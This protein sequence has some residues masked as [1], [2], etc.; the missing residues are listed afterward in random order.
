M[1]GILATRR[2]RRGFGVAP[3]LYMLGLVGVG[4]GILFSSYSQSI[5]ANI[6]LTNSLAVKNDLTGA[7][8]TLASSAVLDS[9]QTYLCPPQGGIDSSTTTNCTGATNLSTGMIELANVT[10]G[11]VRLPGNAASAAAA[12]SPVEVG[13]F[14]PGSGVKQID[15]WGH[16]YIY[17]RWENKAVNGSDPEITILSAGP[18][19][20]LQSNCG[21]QTACNT[22]SHCDDII[23][24]LNVS[25]TLSHDTLWQAGTIGSTSDVRYG[26]L[27]VDA[28]G[29]V[30][31]PGTLT[32]D[33]SSLLDSL[34]TAAAGITTGSAT[35][36]PTGAISGTSGTFGAV[37]SADNGNFITG[38]GGTVSAANGAFTINTGGAFNAATNQFTVSS[39]GDLA[40][41]SSAF[42]VTAATGNTSIG[43]T[44]GV[45]GMVSLGS[46]MSTIGAVH[47]GTTTASGGNPVYLL[48]VGTPEAG[49]PATYPFYVD[50]S[51]NVTAVNVNAGS[52]TAG[53]VSGGS[54]SA[55]S[56]SDSGTATLSGN[57]TVG[58][59]LAV[60]GNLTGS[61]ATFSG[62]VTAQSFS[63][64]MNI[65]SSGGSGVT[66]TG[67]LPVA[68][69]GTGE[70]DAA[71]ALTNL[72]NTAG[73]VS[74]IIPGADLKSG[75]V[76]STQLDSPASSLTGVYYNNVEVDASGRIIAA[77]NTNY[78]TNS[79]TD[80]AGDAVTVGTS[81]GFT[82][83][84][85]STVMENIT[86]TGA[87]VGTS[88]VAANMLDVYGNASIG[89]SYS[90]IA[91][92]PNGLIVAGSVGIG[93]SN[94]T[95]ALT[96]N[97]TVTAG[98]FV[99][100]GSGLTGINGGSINTG[101]TQGS[102][103]FIGSSGALAQNNGQF[104]WD[105]TNDRLGIGTPAP[106]APLHIVS[107][108][109]TD[110]EVD[111]SNTA[112]ATIV[113]N[114]TSLG[115]H[116]FVVNATGA[117]NWAGEFGISDKTTGMPLLNIDGTNG[118]VGIAGYATVGVV[119]LPPAG[120][121]LVPGRVGIGSNNPI[122][123]LDLSQETDAIALPNGASS[124]R[125]T[126]TQLANGEIR[127]NSGT[128]AVEYWN[129]TTWVSLENSGSGSGI[130]LG[131]SASATNPSR[132]GDVTTGLYSDAAGTVEIASA[133]NMSFSNSAALTLIP[134]G[135]VGI[136]TTSPQAPFDVEVK[137]PSAP[138]WDQGA[139][140]W[141]Q[142]TDPVA[143]SHGL[144]A[145]NTLIMSS[146]NNTY[147]AYGIASEMDEI[148][149]GKSE[150]NTV[151]GLAG[152][153]S[154]K[155][156][157]SAGSISGLGGVEGYVQAN[158]AD[159]VS[160][161]TGVTGLV[162]NIGTGSITNAYA[163]YATNS[164]KSNGSIT[165]GYGVYIENQT[166]ATNNW[167]LYSAGGNNYFGGNVGI[168]TTS[169]SATLHLSGAN[170]NALSGTPLFR[171]SDTT[172][173]SNIAIDNGAAGNA[174]R[175][176]TGNGQTAKNIELQSGSNS[177]Q[178]VLNTNGNVG[179]GS[180]SP[181]VSLD[182]SQKTDA[183]AL[184]NGA[185]SSRPTGTALANGEIRYNSGTSAVEYWNGTTWVSLENSGSGSGIYLGASAS[186]T[187][188]SRNGD[189]TTGLYSDA[190]GTVEIA[191]GGNMS[192]SN[193]AALTLIPTGSVGIGTTSP[194]SL[195]D[196][197]GISIDTANFS[198][199]FTQIIQNIA[200][201]SVG[202]TNFR[203]FQAQM[204]YTS[205][206]NSTANSL[207]AQSGY[208]VD[209]GTGSIGGTLKA[210]SGSVYQIPGAGTVSS[211]V[212][213]YGDVVSTGTASITNAYG[214]QF[215]VNVS[216]GVTTGYGLYVGA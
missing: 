145:Q 123:S 166:G 193:S 152:Y 149:N 62:T 171:L 131:A 194:Q 33:G 15:P 182:L 35:M 136:G 208:I 55:S 144:Y 164:F 143:S 207:I 57:T 121:F 69:G 96:V 23:Y 42:S 27:S 66:F 165:N 204:N 52:V 108:A 36:S 30:I 32:V 127:Y 79:I 37:L 203:T 141:Y 151:Y 78:A 163:L 156:G 86:K 158:S 2:A 39:A 181:L 41:G 48:S 190:A 198:P 4:A 195:V 148:T 213:V 210:L 186:A 110:I 153:A 179:I 76:T 178:L 202:S 64:T 177:Y 155:T 172:Q 97:G 58:G 45:T 212:G 21:A 102:V 88:A 46:S 119:T 106:S 209:S 75:T 25:N 196:V 85:G 199:N 3:I 162:Q 138:T 216:S 191:S 61:N 1:H 56:I 93:T 132:N 115:G 173:S 130:Y 5:K 206:Q 70:S 200:P 43:G 82:V 124:S 63:G 160:S 44:L 84:V 114:N 187:N 47:V 185:S 87:M 90:N 167:A 133:G 112:S 6:S 81:S 154:S 134:T 28:N 72:F 83:T 107:S 59:T 113:L 188:P 49:S 31:V 214:G 40:I 205:A 128:S 53:S 197:E 94:P 174:F 9:T 192:F 105:N 111:S 71:S 12:G 7:A 17:C 137:E 51:G 54:V 16:Y 146:G 150:S 14:A 201:V 101:F 161:A 184:P 68:N 120:S 77:F 168:G 11:D 215:S 67:V 98:A 116:Q 125:P 80:G 60:T 22:T 91:A 29:N 74:G 189:V 38:A 135:S 139:R 170:G 26:N 180:S 159:T 109:S 73:T 19:G 142:K 34:V 147:D 20:I 65:G 99:G 157:S 92:P 104:F 211:A 126:G 8:T 100:D 89:T 140:F 117:S 122:V 169:P 50:Q 10:P 129:G 175:L 95:S 118:T 13:I 103:V 18:D 24:S 176:V 183:L